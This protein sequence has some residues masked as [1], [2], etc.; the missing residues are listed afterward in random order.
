MKVIVTCGPASEPIDE[1][2]RITNFST[3]ELGVLLSTE[4]VR[5]G[6]EVFCFKGYGAVY[7]GPGS[8]CHVAQFTTND[9]LLHLLT[10]TAAAHEIG[11]VFHAAALCDYKVGAVR[12]DQGR[13]CDSPKIASRAGA[14]TLTLVPST[15]VISRLREIFPGSVIVGW[16]YELAGTPIDAMIK[17][18]RQLADNGTDICILN[19]R[20]YGA[21]FGICRNTGLILECRDKQNLVKHLSSQIEAGH[22]ENFGNLKQPVHC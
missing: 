19:G 11:A 5:S 10:Q 13:T 2:R 16:K 12:D 6:H 22:K 14:L 9:D 15:K 18:S 17:A 4:L 21:G 7:P 8:E 20:A 3:G 1:V